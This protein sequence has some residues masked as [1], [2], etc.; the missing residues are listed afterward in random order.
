M[1]HGGKYHLR[2]VVVGSP[3]PHCLIHTDQV[4]TS[5]TFLH[6]E[7]PAYPARHTMLT[8]QAQHLHHYPKCA[9]TCSAEHTHSAAT[10]AACHSCTL[11]DTLS[12]S[13]LRHA[14]Q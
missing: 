14:P 5:A 2:A 3:Q 9:G 10:T 12:G 13:C 4:S 8:L 1:A 6:N 11:H 7:R